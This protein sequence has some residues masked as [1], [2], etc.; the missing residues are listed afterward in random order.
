MSELKCGD[1]LGFICEISFELF[2][3]ANFLYM[4]LLLIIGDKGDLLLIIIFEGLT[5]SVF[6]FFKRFLLL[7]LFEDLLLFEVNLKVS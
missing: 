7:L 4:Y 1:S 6:V 5:S 3:L 2:L